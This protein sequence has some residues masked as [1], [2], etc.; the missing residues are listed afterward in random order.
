ML[1]NTI[2]R[3]GD[4]FIPRE[5]GQQYSLSPQTSER[6]LSEAELRELGWPNAMPEVIVANFAEMER[7]NMTV[8]RDTEE[9]RSSGARYDVELSNGEYANIL[10][11]PRRK[12][13]TG[14]FALTNENNCFL[15]AEGQD[16]RQRG[17][18]IRGGS[19]SYL[20]NPFSITEN[21]GVIAT[22]FHTPGQKLGIPYFEVEMAIA[23]ALGS[24]FTTWDNHQ[25]IG[26]SA[27]SHPHSQSGRVNT[28]LRNSISNP[29]INRPDERV[30]IKLND[31][32][33]AYLAGALIG[34]VIV[35]ES[36]SETALKDALTTLDSKLKD[37]PDPTTEAPAN[38]TLS[39]DADGGKYTLRYH[40]RNSFRPKDL[41]YDV[42]NE[43]PI[44]FRVSGAALEKDRVIPVPDAYPDH[45]SAE[46]FMNSGV[47]VPV[48]EEVIR[49]GYSPRKGTLVKLGSISIYEDAPNDPTVRVAA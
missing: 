14:N 34:T 49:Y 33:T 17:I 16:P 41:I 10:V 31:D 3:P 23:K 2:E 11:L 45:R 18:L 32:V 30:P 47:I 21:H 5:V 46:V 9:A 40:P 27:R 8:F 25:D 42:P 38:R 7:K 35:V 15:D 20:N 22:N 12:R 43:G 44:V 36:G 28:P 1:T 13:N 29:S 24:N 4:L 19:H 39:Y 26:A 6:S 37:A 48:L